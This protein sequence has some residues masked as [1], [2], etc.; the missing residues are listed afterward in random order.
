[1]T[2]VKAPQRKTVKSW[3]VREPTTSSV[4]GMGICQY[5]HFCQVAV[6]ERVVPYWGPVVIEGHVLLELLLES[7]SPM[8]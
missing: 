1:M 7:N 6:I 5:C 4:P 2:A 8:A 3:K